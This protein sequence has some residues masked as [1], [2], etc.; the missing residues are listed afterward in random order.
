MS[1]NKKAIIYV[2]IS[3]SHISNKQLSIENQKKSC[4]A[5]AQKNNYEVV[6]II[7]D[8]MQS[9]KKAFPKLIS[10]IISDRSKV[11]LL[12]GYQ[13]DR[14]SRNNSQFFYLNELLQNK[15]IDI[16]IAS[17]DTVLAPSGIEPRL[18]G[19]LIKNMLFSIAQFEHEMKAERVA[20]S[21]R[22]KF[23]KGYWLWQ[24]PFGYKKTK[25][26][27]SLTVDTNQ[28]DVVKNIFR[29]A[30]N[31]DSIDLDL[32]SQKHSLP[33]N[34][35]RKILTNPFYKGEMFSKKWNLVVQGKHQPLVDSKTWEKAQ[36]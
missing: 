4:I 26:G 22:V 31:Q 17:S 33:K 19:N 27:E 14:F 34:T 2:R 1:K 32:I 35:I 16:A 23:E 36:I 30:S 28:A 6:E 10:R 9:S 20:E 15:G 11:D 5:Y 18:P 25:K 13:I 12:I 8:Y 3:S 29:E 24:C 21:M 7:S